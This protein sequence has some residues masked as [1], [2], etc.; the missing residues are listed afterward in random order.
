M[1]AASAPSAASASNASSESERGAPAGAPEPREA[2]RAAM[3]AK[4]PTWYD[5]TV[6]LAIPT[7]LGLAVMI[8]ASLLIHGLRWYELFALPVTIFFGFLFEWRA[9]K[10]ILHKRRPLLGTLYVRHELIHHVVFTYDTMAMQSPREL[11]LILMPAYAIVAVFVML[12]PLVFGLY[13]IFNLNVTLL[14]LI[15]S[16]VFFLTYEW[17]HMAYHLPETTWLGGRKIIARLREVHRR[18]H[19]PRLMK[20]W[21]FNVTVP[22]FDWILGTYWSPEREIERDRQRGERGG[23]GERGERGE[24]ASRQR[25]GESPAPDRA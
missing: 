15:A 13:W 22:V 20:R 24:R 25:R 2:R 17:L 23:R 7:L 21:N 12:L 16:M 9:H 3:V 19:D 6:H 18:H 1:S 4:I 11:W 14:F 5:P 10:F 8:G